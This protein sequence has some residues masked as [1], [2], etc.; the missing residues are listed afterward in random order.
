MRACHR[1]PHRAWLRHCVKLDVNVCVQHF[2]I[3]VG[4]RR[5]CAISAACLQS[6]CVPSCG[7]SAVLVGSAVV[8]P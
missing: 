2:V 8:Q 5:A 7:P 3:V 4:V 6:S 1:A